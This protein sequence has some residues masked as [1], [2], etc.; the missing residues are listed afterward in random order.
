MLG[1]RGYISA[2]SSNCDGIL[3]A[4]SRERNIALYAQEG[5]GECTTQFSLADQRDSLYTPNGN[6]ISQLAWSPDGTY[7]IVAERKSNGIQVF[8]VRNTHQRVS[9]LSGR[10]AVAWQKLGID[11]VPTVTGYEVWAG[12]T[13]GCVRMWKNPG[14]LEDEQ[15]PDGAVK[16]HEGKTFYKTPVQ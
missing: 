16:V 15:M 1:C 12:G 4:G 2:L 13:D 8:D 5:S 10:N 3:A 6:G 7:L 9:W 14:S 11:I